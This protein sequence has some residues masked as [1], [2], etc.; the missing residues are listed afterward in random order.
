MDELNIFGSS[1]ARKNTYL[2]RK[3]ES[4]DSAHQVSLW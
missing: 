2:R 4:S 3:P 1:C